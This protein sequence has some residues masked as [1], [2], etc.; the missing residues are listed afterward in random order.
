MFPTTRASR[1]CW[2]VP[3]KVENGAAIGSWPNRMIGK[4]AYAQVTVDQGGAVKL[5]IDGWNVNQ[6]TP[7][8][9]TMTGRAADNRIDADGRW[10]N[11]ARVEGHW[12]RAP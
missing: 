5:V 11:G 9:G 12:T 4:T 8:T 7:L 1:A 3:L 10:A 6:G 2:R